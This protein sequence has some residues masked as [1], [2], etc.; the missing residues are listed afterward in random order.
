[1]NLEGSKISSTEKGVLWIS[2]NLVASGC[3]SALC[4]PFRAQAVLSVPALLWADYIYIYSLS[5]RRAG[6]PANLH[7]IQNV[8]RSEAMR[9]AGTI[10]APLFP[11]QTRFDPVGPPCGHL[12]VQISD[13][14]WGAPKLL[15]IAGHLVKTCPPFISPCSLLCFC[16]SLF[17]NLRF[18][19]GRTRE[20]QL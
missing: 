4:G 9:H 11:A 7:F 5:T 1:M 19:A 14:S 2:G 13:L 20:H 6:A 3:I 8:T 15:F 17:A 18:Y 10:A 12:K 16:L